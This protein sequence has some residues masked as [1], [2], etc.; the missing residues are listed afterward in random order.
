M[1]LKKQIKK[2]FENE[3][4]KGNLEKMCEGNQG[5]NLKIKLKPFCWGNQGGERTEEPSVATDIARPLDTE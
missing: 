1:I 4:W 2:Q 3:T 5:G